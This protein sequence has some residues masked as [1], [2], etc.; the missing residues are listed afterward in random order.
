MPL[1]GAIVK[2]TGTNSVT[3]G[4]DVTFTSD[5]QTIQNGL[6]LINAADTDYRTRASITA[7]YRQ[8]SLTNGVYSKDKKSLTLQMPILLESGVT[9]FNLIRIERE[10]HPETT[11][12]DAL[13]FN[14]QG[15]QL[16]FDTDFTNFWSVGS[17]A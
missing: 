1:N 11:A 6:H 3:G 10:I 9:V 13:E 8:P 7:K 4:T 2:K 15:A 17:M 14:I 12:A 5:G 16:L